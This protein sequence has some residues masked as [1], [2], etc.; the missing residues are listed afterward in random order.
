MHEPVPSYAQELSRRVDT[1]F[2]RLIPGKLVWRRNVSVWPTLLLWAPCHT[3]DPALYADIPWSETAP[4]LWIRSERQTL[5]RLPDTGA[6]LFTIRVQSM[7]VAVLGRRPD[8]ARDLASWLRAPVGEVRRGQLGCR[9][10]G[11]L[12][13]LDRIAGDP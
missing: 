6:I 1:L 8:R 2:D 7:P 3:L 12:G 10:E 9:T 11:L 4:P 13:W 5:R